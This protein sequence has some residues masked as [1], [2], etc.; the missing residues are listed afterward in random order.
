MLVSRVRWSYFEVVMGFVFGGA[1]AAHTVAGNGFVFGGSTM[2]VIPLSEPVDSFERVVLAIEQVESNGDPFAHRPGSQF[3]GPFQMGRLAALDVG[4]SDASILHGNRDLALWAFRRYVARYA[5]Y[6]HYQ[7]DL[8][9]VLWKGGPGTAKTVQS[10]LD[11]GQPFASALQAAAAKH[12]IPNLAE[13]VSRFQR[14]L[15]AL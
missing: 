11:R 14:E 2:P 10:L 5:K 3:W 12:R 8:V 7:P 15:A 9:A 1:A 6:H 4:I 13:Y